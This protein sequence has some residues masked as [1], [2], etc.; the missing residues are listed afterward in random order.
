MMVAM[1]TM[2]TILEKK[3]ERR[4]EKAH[5]PNLAIPPVQ[6]RVYAHKVWPA[7]VRPLER[8]QV[9]TVRVGP[10]CADEYGGYRSVRGQVGGE[11]G[12]HRRAEPA[13]V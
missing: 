6:H 4:K 12:A 2:V 5:R 3:R 10:A 11:A 1:V 13:Q 7:V 9:G 8:L